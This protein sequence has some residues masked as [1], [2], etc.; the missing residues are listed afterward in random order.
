MSE[1]GNHVIA[2]KVNDYFDRVV[3]I[4]LDRR[5]DRLAQFR[6]NFDEHG[7]CFREPEHF[8]A[9]DGNKVPCPF[10]FEQ[11]G[12]AWGCMQSHRQI[13]ERAIMDDIGILLVLEDD[14]YMKSDSIPRLLQFLDSVPDDWDQLMLG[15]QHIGTPTRVK[16][17][18]VKCTNCQ[19]THAYAIR[20]QFMRDL[21]SKWCSPSSVVHIDW[22]MGP[23]QSLRNVYAPEPFIFGQ[24]AG[25]SDISGRA[26]PRK[27][28][29]TPAANLPVVFLEAPQPVVAELRRYGLHTG[30]NRDPKTDLDRG[31]LRV[32]ASDN[33]SN[34]LHKWIRDMQWE[35]AS[36]EGLTTTIWH[37]D[38]KLEQVKNC[39]HG[40]VIH[41]KADNL[42]E[43]LKQLP[44]AKPVDDH[45]R[46][47]VVV[48]TSPKVVIGQ[49][50]GLGWHSGNWRD[51]IT[52]IDNG[53][54]HI[55]ANEGDK[56][57]ALKKWIQDVGKEV[58]GRKNGVLVI[59]HPDATPELVEQCTERKVVAI[60]A[61]TTEDALD[62]WRNL[63]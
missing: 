42:D 49:L 23:L 4:N 25:Q 59:W 50:R 45:S 61:K 60:N 3:L 18:V 48:L 24:E 17:G 40:E 6:A 20:G 1:S 11:G 55:F 62:Q 51:H 21:Y 19:R 36:D 15:G 56:I 26:N 58:E 38:A 54:R 31:L 44:D 47:H 30:Y 53:L 16:E 46:S 5:P 22:I 10:G 33:P 37:P 12:G 28:W 2:E 35:V 39:T 43:A 7:W 29:D 27:S 8:R 34:E 57:P 63:R 41:V 52:D 32:F 9:I 14:A 13:L